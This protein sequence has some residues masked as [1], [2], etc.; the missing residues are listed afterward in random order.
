M[1]TV[2]KMHIFV[3]SHL[4]FWSGNLSLIA[5]FP[6]LCLLVPFPVT[7]LLVPCSIWNTFSFWNISCGLNK[8]IAMQMTNDQF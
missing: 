4:G 7:I 6:D 8:G 3:F 5:P 2:S 1:Y